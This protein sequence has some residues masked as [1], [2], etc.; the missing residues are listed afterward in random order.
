M[1]GELRF[2]PDLGLFPNVVRDILPPSS[3]NSSRDE[4]DSVLASV[5]ETGRVSIKCITWNMQ[6]KPPPEASVLRER[7]FQLG[8]VHIFVVG[9]EECE[10]TIAK[11]V[12]NPSKAHWE[13]VLSETFGPSFEM[14]CGHTLQATHSIVFV[15][16]ALVPFVTSIK[17]HAVSTGIKLGTSRLGNKGGI[18]I[19][20]ALGGSAFLF[21]NCHLAHAKKGLERRNEEYHTIAS[22]LARNLAPASTEE[23]IDEAT[24]RLKRQFDCIVW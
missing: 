3:E 9:S 14:L 18:G 12:L 2:G 19:S 5:R 1:D 11:S 7:I 6:A 13:S 23:S 22:A 4:D 16:R 17:S 21:V 10:N 15:H 24:A 20:F 8:E